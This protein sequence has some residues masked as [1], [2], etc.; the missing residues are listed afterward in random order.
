MHQD[1]SQDQKTNDDGDEVAVSKRGTGFLGSGQGCIFRSAASKLHKLVRKIDAARCEAGDWH[2]QVINHGAD[3]LAECAAQNHADGEVER[4][5]F[6]CKFF[7]FI[8]HNISPLDIRLKKSHALRCPKA[9]P[10]LIH[11][12][13]L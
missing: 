2:D 5:A 13:D 10:L 9:G 12:P 6:E 1:E 3:D 11:S 7:E 4:I 8:P